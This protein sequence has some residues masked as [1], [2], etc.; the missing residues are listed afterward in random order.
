MNEA[1]K[2]KRGVPSDQCPIEWAADVEF[3]RV[4]EC[5]NLKG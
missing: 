3:E 4:V 2:T 5:Y 1:A